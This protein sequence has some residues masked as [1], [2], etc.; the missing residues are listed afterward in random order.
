MTLQTLVL[1]LLATAF[2]WRLGVA[3][4]LLYLAEGAAGLP[5]FAG[6]PER[7][8]GL[9]YLAGPTAGYLLGFVPAAWAMGWLAERGWDRVPWRGLVLGLAGNAIVIALGAAWLA[10]LLGPARALALG[11]SPFLLATALKA[12]LGATLLTAL[13]RLVALR[14]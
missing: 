12:T 10:W 13:W 7:G 2:G 4:V 1:Q 14:R 11:V 9:A 5:V 8:L 6:S 3:T